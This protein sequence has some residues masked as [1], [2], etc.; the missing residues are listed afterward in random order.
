MTEGLNDK[1]NLESTAGA[2]DIS[3]VNSVYLKGQVINSD[4]SWFE[5]C[6]IDVGV[7]GLEVDEGFHGELE[8]N[9]REVI[10]YKE[11]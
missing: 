2:K 9:I 7:F 5:I 10:G 11:I 1:S 6:N 4:E 8:N 3:R